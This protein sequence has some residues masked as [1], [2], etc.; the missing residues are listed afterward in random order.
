MDVSASIYFVSTAVCCVVWKRNSITE[1][2]RNGITEK[3]SWHQ[4]DRC[5]QPP[6]VHTFVVSD[7]TDCT[8]TFLL[9]SSAGRDTKGKLSIWH[10][11]A[12]C[13][14]VWWKVCVWGGQGQSSSK[15]G[16]V[17]VWGAQQRHWWLFLHVFTSPECVWQRWGRG[18]GWHHS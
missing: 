7:F 16:Q 5:S 15:E 18:H 14:C 9:S 13:G 1:K 10:Q 12:W 2:M 4:T 11:C 17:S 8:S 6:S 3:M